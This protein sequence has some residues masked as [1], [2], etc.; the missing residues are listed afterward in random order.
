MKIMT[1]LPLAMPPAAIIYSWF[2]RG[3]TC[4]HNAQLRQCGYICYVVEF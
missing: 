1:K 4:M 2:Q 3:K